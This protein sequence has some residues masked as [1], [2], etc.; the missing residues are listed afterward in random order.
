M[1]TEKLVIIKLNPINLEK[2]GYVCGDW[3]TASPLL[4]SGERTSDRG[5]KCLLCISIRVVHY[6]V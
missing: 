3:N 6:P 5:G 1:K 4:F 2:T